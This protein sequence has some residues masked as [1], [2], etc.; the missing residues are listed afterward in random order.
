MRTKFAIFAILTVFVLNAAAVPEMDK[1]KGIYEKELARLKSESQA[2]KLRLP[3]DHIAAMRELERT[4]QQSGELKSLLAVRGERERFIGNPSITAIVPVTTP[5]H[6]RTLQQSYIE[7]YKSLSSDRKTKIGDLREKYIRALENLQKDLTRQ[8]KIESALAVMKEIESEQDS[9]EG[10]D[11]AADSGG[12]V[13]SPD[14]IAKPRSTTLD[15]DALNELLHGE[16]RRWNSYSRQITITYDFSEPEQM[17]DWKGGELDELRGLLVCERTVAWVRPQFLKILEVGHDAFF[18]EEHEHLAGLVIGNSIQAHLTGGTVLEA[19]LFQTSEQHPL[20]RFVEA[21]SPSIRVHRSELTI[22]NGRVE[23]TVDRTRARRAILQVPI[24]YPTYVGVGHMGS[25]SAY[26][27]ITITGIL[28]K[29]YEAY[30]K[31]QL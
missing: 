25:R 24:R 22:Q 15:I 18:D 10:G 5:D 8:G 17:E 28:S 3:Q 26:D 23:W 29:E 19:K 27:N 31:Q 6:L 1:L 11:N 20:T 14:L 9:F 13:I 21:G 2:E 4:Y 30:L 16:V 7:Q 12:A